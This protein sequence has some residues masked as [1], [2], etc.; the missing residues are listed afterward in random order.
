MK[1]HENGNFRSWYSCGVLRM[2]LGLKSLASTSIDARF[3]SRDID[4][5]IHCRLLPISGSRCCRQLVH[6]T[7]QC[8]LRSFSGVVLVGLHSCLT[9]SR[10]AA[11]GPFIRDCDVERLFLCCVVR[12]GYWPDQLVVR[13]RVVASFFLTRALPALAVA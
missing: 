9:C 13:S 3:I 6:I 7:M 5:Q 2:E 8:G 1:L 4:G 10:G 12:V 11:V